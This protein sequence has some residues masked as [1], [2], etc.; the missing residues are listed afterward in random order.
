MKKGEIS[1][2]EKLTDEGR[3]HVYHKPYSDNLCGEYLAQIGAI[4]SI[5]PSP[6]G[7]LL[8][9]GC[10][11]GWTS[12][13]FAKRGY[14]V[15]GVDIAPDMNKYANNHAE[16][17]RT[18]VKGELELFGS[19]I[20]GKL[21]FESMDYENMDFSEQFDLAVFYD[22]LHHCE[23]ESSALRSVFEALKVGGLCIL[24]EPGSGHAEVEG[25][26]A[27][28]NEYGVNEKDMPPSKIWAYAK[29]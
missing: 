27:A 11:A 23:D 18:Q 10:G 7:K 25:S 5:L 8:D 21:A 19:S 6:P 1:Y 14:D 2:L 28:V 24:S 13:M 4:L 22:S 16:L 3:K 15:I 20:V 26:V 29:M 17:L 9:I 12:L